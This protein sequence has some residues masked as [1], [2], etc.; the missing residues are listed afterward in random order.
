[1]N[2]FQAIDVSYLR[3]NRTIETI[4][5][6]N[7]TFERILY[8]Y[9]F[10]GTHFRVFESISDILKFFVDKLEPS[11][12]FDNEIQLEDYLGYIDL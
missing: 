4:L 1:M 8:V 3:P 6:K 5:L 10:E 2:T 7:S 9:N 12:S 11:I